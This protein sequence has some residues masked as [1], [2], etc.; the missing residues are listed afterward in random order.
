MWPTPSSVADVAQLFDH[1]V[2]RAEDDLV[3]VLGLLVR[4]AV[5]G[6]GDRAQAADT[7]DIDRRVPWRRHPFARLLVERAVLPEEVV[8]LLLGLLLGVRHEDADQIADVL[9]P[10]S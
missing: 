4:L 5:E 6:L 7:R 2:G 1:L 9:G 10:I 3:I 8:A